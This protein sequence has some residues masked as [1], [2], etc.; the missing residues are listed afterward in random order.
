MSLDEVDSEQ[1]MTRT[2]AQNTK[3][4]SVNLKQMYRIKKNYTA[5]KSNTLALIAALV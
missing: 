2:D 1:A 4:E 5:S 3:Q